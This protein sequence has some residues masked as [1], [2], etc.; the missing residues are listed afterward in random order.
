LE[1]PFG[2]GTEGAKRSVA[3][4]LIVCVEA[5]TLKTYRRR[6]INPNSE[7][8]TTERDIFVIIHRP[9]Y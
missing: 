7:I 1:S 2:I 9:F 8:T 6:S 4:L 3:Q 5:T